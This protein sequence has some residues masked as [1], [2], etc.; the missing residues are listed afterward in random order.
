MVRTHFVLFLNCL[1]VLE[2]I[3]IV[4]PGIVLREIPFCWSDGI[5]FYW[6][7]ILDL[8]RL[9][10][11]FFFH[12]ILDYS[13]SYEHFNTP[14]S[15][16]QPRKPISNGL[17]QEYSSSFWL[18]LHTGKNRNHWCILLQGATCCFTLTN[19]NIG[20]FSCWKMVVRRA[21]ASVTPG[22]RP[23]WLHLF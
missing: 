19:W 6:S 2:M 1:G 13:F 3:R 20:V 18:W 9:M 15:I 21:Y 23:W 8:S 17:H 14:S 16:G 7:C 22:T 10:S 4:L 12:P 5:I 11:L